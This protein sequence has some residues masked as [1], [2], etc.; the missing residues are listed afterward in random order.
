MPLRPSKGNSRLA[1]SIQTQAVRE[2]TLGRPS[3]ARCSPIATAVNNIHELAGGP[4]Y[5]QRNS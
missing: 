4:T 2:E 1:R 5:V 3:R